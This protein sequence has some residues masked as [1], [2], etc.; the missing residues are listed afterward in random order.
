[1]HKKT[2]NA[3][4]VRLLL[5]ALLLASALL[6]GRAWQAQR[7]EMRGIAWGPQP[8]IPHA[9]VYPLG[10]NAD[11][12]DYED[13][14]LAQ[15]LAL[16]RDGG[17]HWVRQRFPWAEIEP[18]QGHFD[19]ARWDRL[20]RAVRRHGLSL[21]A[22]LDTSPA[23]ARSPKDGDN[24]YAPPQEP[25][26]FGHFA[27][28]FAQRYGE[29]IDY[30]Q[31]WDEPNIYPHWGEGF[32]D[33]AAYVALLREGYVAIK[34]AD[35]VAF[36]L[37]A[38]LAPTTEKGPLNLNEADFLQG[39]YDAGARDFFDILAAKPYGFNTGP[40]DRRV[41]PAV[42]NFSRLLLLREVMERAGDGTKAIWAVEFG[43]NALPPDWEGA[44]SIWG[45]TSEEEQAR[46]TV[47]ALER[48]RDEWPWLGAMLIRELRPVAPP[49]DP[50][51]GF[52]LIWQDGSRRPVYEELREWAMTP[53]VGVGTHRPDH[54]ALRYEGRW[55]VSPYGADVGQSGDVLVIPFRGTRLDLTVRR[56]DYWAVLYVEVDDAPANALPRDSHGR[57]Y[58]VLYDPLRRTETV[59]LARGLPDGPHRARILAEGGWNQW[60][61]ADF[62]VI[63][64]RGKGPSLLL[65]LST[66]TGLAA[67]ALALS[68]LREERALLALVGRKAASTIAFYRGLDERLRLA[69]TALAAMALY[70]SP[71]FPLDVVALG[72]LAFFVLLE[73]WTGLAVAAFFVPFYPRPKP[74][75]GKG[76]S[77]P[78]VATLL[79]ALGCVPRLLRAMPSGL[80][81]SFSGASASR[82]RG[83]APPL[84]FLLFLGALSPFLAHHRG[85]A[86]REFR[87]VVLEPV[88][89][90]FL[91]RWAAEQG[92]DFRLWNVVD[93]LVAGA[94]VVSAVGLWQF[95]RGEVIVAEGVR[96]VRAFYGSPNN[97]GLFLGRVAP[98]LVAVAL[99]G[100]GRKRRGAYALAL[101]VVFPA[102]YLTYSRGAWF[103]GIPAAL[104]FI[105][106]ARGRRGLL[107]TLAALL[108]LALAILPVM[109]TE[110]WSGLFDIHRGTTFFRL[111]LWQASLQMIKEHPLFGVGLDNFLY[112][113]RTRYVLPEAWQELNLSHP[114]NLLLDWWSRLGLGGVVVLAWLLL[115]FFREAW[116]LYQALPEGDERA[117]TLGL[118]AGMVDCLAHGLID[119][120]YF[121][122]DLAFVFMLMI[123]VIW[124]MKN[125]LILV[126]TAR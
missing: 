61:I 45:S 93:A 78:E 62:R 65:A 20:V 27:R 33:P 40:Y 110:R 50:R 106:M 17:F 36:V 70:L 32:V 44:S 81:A 16:I 105:G 95:A 103:L 10:V 88:I 67:L 18:R 43:W 85:V 121:L 26:L 118:M 84:L 124:G 92:D 6:A 108:A 46:Y 96:R 30:Y 23:W 13:Q 1:M 60:A 102:L 69:I 71:W 115:V 49:D 31:I 97:L 91:L 68:L 111:K 114:H 37:T 101:V 79:A 86:I 72:S 74:F 56:G 90:C 29:D 120:S 12:A 77:M 113:Y 76:L 63:R 42:L 122:V 119:N 123:G 89:F 35:P 99:L 7:V 83:F 126:K 82:L 4:L 98:L 57:S 116:S 53:L 38:G 28:Q 52:A 125:A 2:P 58:L 22:V 104:A 94:V 15:A 55:R 117:L 3:R 59:T 41:S 25:S 73:P 80:R 34:A 11:L 107:L 19:W 64:E 14:E 47:E 100:R 8:F 75:L 39:M 66:I 51:W 54:H 21:I 9:D 48:A 109:G 87:L 24:P 5:G 112:E